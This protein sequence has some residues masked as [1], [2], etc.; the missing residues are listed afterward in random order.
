M[1]REVTDAD[2]ITWTC[3]QAF[4]GLGKDPEKTE[5]ARVEGASNRFHVVCTPSGGAK[6]V[7]V[8][9]PGNWEKGLSDEQLVRA[10]QAQQ[11]QDGK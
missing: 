8:E 9:L 5:A 4:A 1:P 2:G 11:A 3:I 6:S 7:R 10:I